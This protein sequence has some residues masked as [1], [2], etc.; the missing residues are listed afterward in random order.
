M[1]KG[2]GGSGRGEGYGVSRG[3][4]A[5]TDLER[6]RFVLLKLDQQDRL[7][8]VHTHHLALCIPITN[9]R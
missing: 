6:E 5:G 4:E 9:Q 3:K 2:G 8:V 1:K 7:L